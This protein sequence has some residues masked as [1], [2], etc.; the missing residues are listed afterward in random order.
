M[1]GWPLRA[2]RIGAAVVRT[3]T[4]RDLADYGEPF[5]FEHWAS[6]EFF[7]HRLK[8]RRRAVRHHAEPQK[9]RDSYVTEHI[10][11]GERTRWFHEPQW[12]HVFLVFVFVA[13]LFVVVTVT[14]G[15]FEAFRP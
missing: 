5:T 3:V 6:E 11:I 8:P 14:G 10:V 1:A 9:L 2:S 13:V 7:G 4:R 12:R 15:S